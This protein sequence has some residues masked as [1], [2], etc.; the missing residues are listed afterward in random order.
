MVQFW[1]R[2]IFIVLLLPLLYGLFLVGLTYP[3]TERAE[4]GVETEAFACR[5]YLPGK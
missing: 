1:V 3:T 5:D 2:C 4:R